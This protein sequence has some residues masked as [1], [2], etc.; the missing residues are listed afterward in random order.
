MDLPTTGHYC[1]AVWKS[2][3]EDLADTAPYR[4]WLTTGATAAP[5]P[6]PAA[7]RL[8]GATPNPFNPRTVLA[9]AVASDGP[10]RLVIHD[11][12]GRVVRRLVDDRRPAG[13]HEVEFDGRDDDGRSL[14]S[15]VYVARIVT[16]AGT[17]LLK[18]ALVQ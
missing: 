16:A 2:R 5:E 18:L 10:C 3:Y 9:F 8:L 14:P 4:L 15:G 12:Q 17:D 6:L 1:I 13:R 11:L 7:T